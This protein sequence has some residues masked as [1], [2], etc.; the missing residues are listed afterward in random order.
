MKHDTNKAEA[1]TSVNTKKRPYGTLVHKDREHGRRSVISLGLK[2][3]LLNA[4][5]SIS[6][7]LMDELEAECAASGITRSDIVRAGLIRE[8]AYRRYCRSHG[9][10]AEVLSAFSIRPKKREFIKGIKSA[11]KPKPSVKDAAKLR[12]LLK[13]IG[14]I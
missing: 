14:V 10:N 12:K 11:S 5:T 6:K 7:G 4:T 13:S 8:L 9:L 2:G 1:D 3:E